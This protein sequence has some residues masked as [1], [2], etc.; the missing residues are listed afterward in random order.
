VGFL[1]AMLIWSKCIWA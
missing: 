1:Y